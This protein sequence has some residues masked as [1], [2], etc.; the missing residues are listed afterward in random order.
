VNIGEIL[1]RVVCSTSLIGLA[2]APSW[3]QQ[4][5]S[6]AGQV[7]QALES[8]YQAARTLQGDFL[9]RY[10]EGGRQERLESG[11]VFF[12]RPGRMRWEYRSPETKLF[13]SDGRVLWF[14][15]PA[16]HSATR[17]LVKQSDDWRTPLALLTGQV[18]MARLCGRIDLAKGA[19]LSDGSVILQ[20]WPKGEKAPAV[21]GGQQDPSNPFDAGGDFT[22]VLLEVNPASGELNDVRVEQAGGVELDIRFGAWRMNP[23]LAPSL[24]EFEP[25]AGAAIVPGDASPGSAP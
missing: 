24:F 20:C 7:A 15:I 8:H 13:V 17:Q 6:E 18:K 10:S 14:Y 19:P 2:A 12:A 9:E 21:R 16:D 11:R 5:S 4:P 22:E 25:P 23:P 3:A 1:V